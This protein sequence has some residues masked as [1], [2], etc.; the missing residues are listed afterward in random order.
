MEHAEKFKACTKEMKEL[1]NNMQKAC[2]T[3]WGQ[4]TEAMKAKS[5]SLNNFEKTEE[6]M[7]A[8]Q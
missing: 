4:C 8:V 7:G 5:K 6:K 2:A 3:T 1:K